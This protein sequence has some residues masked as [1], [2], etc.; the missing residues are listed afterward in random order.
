MGVSFR[1][2]VVQ[3]RFYHPGLRRLGGRHQQ[4]ADN[5][6]HEFTGMTGK[7]LLYEALNQRPGAVGFNGFEHDR[8]ILSGFAA[9]CQRLIEVK[10]GL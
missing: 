7:I 5:G 8:T 9:K 10:L 2:Y 4:H 6:Q 1:E 3:R